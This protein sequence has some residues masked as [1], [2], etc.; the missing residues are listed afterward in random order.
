MVPD[1]IAELIKVA[2]LSKPHASHDMILVNLFQNL[3]QSEPTWK[4]KGTKPKKLTNNLCEWHIHQLGSEDV[5]ALDLLVIDS[6]RPDSSLRS[7]REFIRSTSDLDLAED[8][9]QAARD[10]AV[11]YGNANPCRQPRRT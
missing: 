10:T 5:L 2:S 11:F 7:W 4:G 3:F 1:W 9:G 8:A 6:T